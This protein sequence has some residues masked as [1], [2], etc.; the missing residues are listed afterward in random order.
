MKKKRI[1]AGMLPFGLA[2]LVAGCPAD[3]EAI[4]LP[5]GRAVDLGRDDT[6]RDA[7]VTPIPSER[8][9]QSPIGEGARGAYPPA[10]DTVGRILD[11]RLG[12]PQ[13]GMQP[14]T[15]AATRPG[16]PR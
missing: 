3:R 9:P 4:E 6:I 16:A 5:D 8:I 2:L 14:D 11:E 13:P 15:P 12:Q 10:G 1:F 7:P